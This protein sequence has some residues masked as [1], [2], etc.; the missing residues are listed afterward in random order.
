MKVKSWSRPKGQSEDRMRYNVARANNINPANPAKMNYLKNSLVFILAILLALIL[1]SANV[2]AIGITPGR[3]TVDFEPNLQKTVSFSVVNSEKINMDLVVYVQGEL[4]GSISLKETS[5]KMSSSEEGREMSYELVLPATLSPGLHSAEVVVLQLPSKT[6][7]ETYVGAAVAVATQLY[8]Y[9][10]YPGKYAEAQ[11]N[12]VNAEQNQEMMFAIPIINR[13]NLG[14]ERV[15]AT[16]DI[17]TKLNEKVGTVNTNEISLQSGERGEVAGK[18][19]VNVSVG[20]YR[21]VATL[22]Y[23]E[24]TLQLEKQFDVGSQ[25]LDLQTIE[26]NNFNLGQIAKFEMLVDNKWSEP[27]SGAYA[28]TQIFDSSGAVMADFKSPSYDIPPLE[29][30]LMISYWDTAGVKTGTYSSRVSLRYGEKSAEKD[31]QLKV[32]NDKIEVIGLGYVI[33]S[34]SSG[35]NNNL[36]LILGIGLGVL[37]LINALW[38]IFLRKK[39]KK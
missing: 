18:W 7:S 2:L 13:G 15:R 21:A 19:N 37:V 29:K 14:L 34:Q 28:Q 12:V 17:Y 31:L 10:P 26:V 3:T 9:V 30:K 32:S 6:S 8:V 27:I 16:I 5:F 11:L 33:S 35:G 36:V 4:N 38:F 20:T 22:I 24:Q 25:V 39:L 1:F 23:D